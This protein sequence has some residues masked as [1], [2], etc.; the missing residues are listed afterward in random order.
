MRGDSD[1]ASRCNDVL[2]FGIAQ[3]AFSEVPGPLFEHVETM[4]TG[5][6]YKAVY[7]RGYEVDTYLVAPRS[8]SFSGIVVKIVH[9]ASE[10]LAKSV[11]QEAAVLRQ[12]RTV[13]ST[14][15]CVWPTLLAFY[16]FGDAHVSVSLKIAGSVATTVCLDRR[17]VVSIAQAIPEI[18]LCLGAIPYGR[19]M[20]PCRSDAPTAY[21]APKIAHWLQ[22]YAGVA[23]DRE[24]LTFFD[25]LE[26][27]RTVAPTIVSDRS[28]A[29]FIVMS[30]DGL[31]CFD[32]G[33]MLVGVP[34]E[35][36]SWFIDDPRLK[37]TLSRNHLIDIFGMECGTGTH[38][39][40]E[41][42][43]HLAAVF[44]CIKQYCLMREA[45][46]HDMAAHY[47]KRAS[48]SADALPFA[49]AKRIVQIISNPPH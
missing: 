32:F 39:S 7:A 48:V 29:N 40:Q 3:G 19:N 4:L 18:Q 22:K 8:G 20:L 34:Q 14:R 26:A 44:V 21:Y 10:R 6:D 42:S 1:T 28:P 24:S 27:R 38:T 43:Y 30:N 12:M 5:R 35:D 2:S 47:L 37:T 23:I 11:A 33:L 49:D 15:M 17:A 13:A 41:L 31:G 16:Q 9:D 25:E 45:G 46:K 36:W